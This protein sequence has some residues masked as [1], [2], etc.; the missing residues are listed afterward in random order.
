MLSEQKK[1]RLNKGLKEY[2]S[3]RRNTLTESTEKEIIQIGNLSVTKINGSFDNYAKSK[4]LINIKDIQW[5][6]K[7]IVHVK[8]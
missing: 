1:K 3:K 2:Y 5:N 6:L 7:I 8:S 4:G